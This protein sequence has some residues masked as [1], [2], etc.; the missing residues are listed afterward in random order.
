MTYPPAPTLQ[1]IEVLKIIARGHPTRTVIWNRRNGRKERVSSLTWSEIQVASHATD[2]VIGDVIA[3]LIAH[4]FIEGAREPPSILGRMTGKSDTYSFIVTDM[5]RR[6]LNRIDSEVALKE[7]EKPAIGDAFLDELSEV[8][9]KLGYNLSP[10]GAGVALASHLSGYS[11]VETASFL[12]LSTLA[13]DAR[14]AGHDI[15]KYFALV[16]HAKAIIDLL[17]TLRGKELIREEIF[18]NDARAMLKVTVPSPEQAEWIHRVLSDPLTSQ[19]RVAESRL[20]YSV[21]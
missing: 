2:A 16:A 1:E 15:S 3:H 10:Y 17:S 7:C 11:L 4:D 20:D 8:M 13:R 5:G 18:Q 19:E 21:R 12:A 9:R 14:E 6:F